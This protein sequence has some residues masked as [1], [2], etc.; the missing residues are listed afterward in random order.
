M[1]AQYWD[2]L[3][4]VCAVFDHQERMLYKQHEF[5]ALC[6]DVPDKRLY[7]SFAIELCEIC[8]L[9]TRAPNS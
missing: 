7:L 2:A 3:Y 1:L 9:V 5:I 4:S 6:H 8:P